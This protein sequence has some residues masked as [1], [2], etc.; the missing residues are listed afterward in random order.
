MCPVCRKPVAQCSCKAD[1]ARV[2][3]LGQ[4]RVHRPALRADHHAVQHLAHDGRTQHARVGGRTQRLQQAHQR[5]SH[6]IVEH[7]HWRTT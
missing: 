4:R 3:V 7:L 6:R 2:A 1:A 5:L